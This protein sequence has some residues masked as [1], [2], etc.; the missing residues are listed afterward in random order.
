MVCSAC[1]RKVDPNRS[2][3]PACGGMVFVGESERHQRIAQPGRPASVDQSVRFGSTP[4]D[5][6]RRTT[7]QRPTPR[8]PSAAS[9][10]CLA[11]VV[12]LAFV[13]AVF[14]F[15]GKWLLSIPE[16]RTL[17]SAFRSGAFSDDQV[18]AAIDAVGAHIRQLFGASPNR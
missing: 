8:M 10:G 17:I 11:T 16:V 9:L 7:I 6:P 12:R 1:G 15:G 14:W 3:C 2:F 5:V 13:G 4:V 18:S